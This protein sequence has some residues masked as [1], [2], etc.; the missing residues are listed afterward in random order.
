MK[1]FLKILFFIVTMSS[2]TANFAVAD[3]ACEKTRRTGCLHLGTLGEYTFGTQIKK[4][5]GYSST[6]YDNVGGCSG[7]F[8]TKALSAV[9]VQIEN[10]AESGMMPAL[11]VKY[12]SKQQIDRRDNEW[13]TLS[14]GLMLPQV[15]VPK[16]AGISKSVSIPEKY[17]VAILDKVKVVEKEKLPTRIQSSFTDSYYY[18][19]E[20]LE[21]ITAFRRFGGTGDEQAKL[22][23]G[24]VSTETILSRRELAILPKWNTMQFEAELI[25]VKGTKVNLGK[26]APQ[27]KYLGGADQVLL[28]L[29]YPENWIK[30]VKD[31]KTG[32]IYNL[33]EFKKAFPNLI[34]N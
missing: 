24:Y 28:P 34:H 5:I 31:L 29:E 10:N 23:G 21:D 33:E 17:Q 4:S 32:K 18:T 11:V 14:T 13:L 2:F 7:M 16:I 30:S 22:L 26:V 9:S 6:L 12:L 8:T 15:F 3:V 1:Q 20:T 19:A 25:I 27:G